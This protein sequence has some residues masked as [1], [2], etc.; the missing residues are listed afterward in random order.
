MH[1]NEIKALLKVR[2]R[3]V[4]KIEIY[5]PCV[6]EYFFKIAFPFLWLAFKLFFAISFIAKKRTHL[7][8]DDIN[9]LDI[10]KIIFFFRQNVRCLVLK[11]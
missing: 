3:L 10:I 8:R 9:F 1:L 7:K 2:N 5:L 6:F 11:L 4:A